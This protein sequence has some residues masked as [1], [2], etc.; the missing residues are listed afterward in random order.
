M[1]CCGVQQR[2][3]SETFNGKGVNVDDDDDDANVR[4]IPPPIRPPPLQTKM[5]DSVATVVRLQYGAHARGKHNLSQSENAFGP[6]GL[7]NQKYF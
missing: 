1:L 7:V 3:Q 6:D 4:Y 5:L 2:V